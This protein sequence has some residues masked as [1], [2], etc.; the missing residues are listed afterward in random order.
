MIVNAI[1]HMLKKEESVF[2]SVQVGKCTRLVC[3]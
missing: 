1:E 3:A 2:D